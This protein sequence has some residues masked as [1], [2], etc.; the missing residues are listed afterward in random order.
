MKRVMEEHGGLSIVDPRDVRVIVGA[1]DWILETLRRRAVDD[2][3]MVGQTGKNVGV[4]TK[5]P[6]CN[7]L[8]N[9]V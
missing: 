7:Q 3:G 1:T 2:D 8:P 9:L 4:V 5:P 6:T